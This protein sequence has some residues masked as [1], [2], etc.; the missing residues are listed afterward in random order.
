M[1]DPTVSF[2]ENDF[3]ADTE[4]LHFAIHTN[5]VTQLSHLLQQTSPPPDLSHQFFHTGTPLH[6]ASEIGDVRAVSILLAAGADPTV[7]CSRNDTRYTSLGFAASNNHVDVVRL[8][9]KSRTPEQHNEELKPWF[10]GLTVAAR[11]GSIGVVEVLLDLWDGWSYQVRA[12]ALCHGSKRWHLNVVRLLLERTRFEKSELT[13]A[14]HGAADHRDVLDLVPTRGTYGIEYINQRLLVGVLIDAGADPNIPCSFG[15]PP[16]CKTSYHENLTGALEMLLL[17]GANPNAVDSQGLTPLHILAQPVAGNGW[18]YSLN[19]TAVR[20]VLQAKGSP[21]QPSTRGETPLHWAAQGAD[22]RV[23]LLYLSS[24][25]DMGP[26]Q[27]LDS[28]TNYDETILHFA[29]S[30][31]RVEIIE[32]LISQGANVNARDSSGWTPLMCA[33]VLAPRGTGTKKSLSES[34]ESAELLLAQGADPTV[35]TNEG[36]TALHCLALH[37]DHDH[38]GTVA[39]L[40]QK[41]VELGANP[42]ARAPLLSPLN[43]GWASGLPWGQQLES[44]M[45]APAEAGWFIKPAMQPLMWAAENGALGVIRG[46]LA[47]Q[48]HSVLVSDGEKGQYAARMAMESVWLERQEDLREAVLQ[49]FLEA[50]AGI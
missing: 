34:I 36:W 24:A 19:E 46:L 11:H 18:R 31:G 35:V 3:D 47:L 8:L 2:R 16:V 27:L 42:L 1:R 45:A 26:Q 22:L 28:K 43:K 6:Y 5:N 32:Y 44:I 12:L 7:L 13:Q 9:W 10:A 14:L 20:M 38:D 37:A 40:A 33:L 48:N 41:L 49:T 4:P 21:T 50:G 15:Y 23:F 17:K 30:G 25:T 29:A 39:A